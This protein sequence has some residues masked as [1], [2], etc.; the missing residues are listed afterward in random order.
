[1]PTDADKHSLAQITPPENVRHGLRLAL[2]PWIVFSLGIVTNLQLAFIGSV[3][4]ALFTLGLKPVPVS[5]GIA[6]LTK[7][8]AILLLAW[9]LSI[10]FLPY[11]VVF[12]IFVCLGVLLAYRLQIKTGDLLLSV[13]AVIAALLVPFLA[14]MDPE[15]AGTIAYWL[16][17]NVA[18]AM[19]VSWL[20]FLVLPE[21]DA[22]EQGTKKAADETNVTDAELQMLRLAAVVIPFVFFA[23]VFDFITPFVLVFV[24]IQSSQFVADTSSQSRA[25]WDM[26]TA[27]MIGGIAAVLVYELLVAV[28]FLPFVLVTLFAALAWFSRQFI[29][30]DTR[31][32]SA[33]TA[34]LIL[35]GGTLM[36]FSDDAQ[37]KMIFRLWQ[38]G[39]AFAYLSLAFAIVDRFAPERLSKTT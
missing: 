26:L 7:S 32:V 21:L 15:L 30:G 4:A 28:P 37:T 31:I 39:A 20:V 22:S 2:A 29:A 12:L 27:N 38:L 33:I 36:P 8:A 35:I 13:F 3:F 34:F 9:G 10:W 24:A 6:L 18:V 5:Y 16:I 17:A 11:P 19:I 14:R 1:M 23:F 25:S